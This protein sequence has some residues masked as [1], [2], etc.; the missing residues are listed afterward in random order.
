MRLKPC[1]AAPAVPQLPSPQAFKAL[2]FGADRSGCAQTV[3]RSSSCVSLKLS[4]VED[5]TAIKVQAPVPACYPSCLVL[6]HGCLECNMFMLARGMFDDITRSSMLPCREESTGT[7]DK[8]SLAV[9]RNSWQVSAPL[10]CCA[11]RRVLLNR[12]R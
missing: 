1:L 12:Q 11:T 2:H 3:M 5:Q 7:L 6:L 8:T 10:C 9:P 4:F